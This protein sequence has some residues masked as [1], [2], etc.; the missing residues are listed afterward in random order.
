MKA[1]G[2]VDR[3]VSG[4]FVRAL[5]G[6]IALLAGLFVVLDL[7]HNLARFAD[8]RDAFT[9]FVAYYSLKAPLFISS[10]FPLGALAGAVIVAAGLNRRRELVTLRAAGVSASRAL[11]MVVLLGGLL[12]AAHA[13]LRSAAVPA[14]MMALDVR[15]WLGPPREANPPFV[16]AR[17]D[18]PG[19]VRHWVY[20][21]ADK[22]EIRDLSVTS[23]SPDGTMLWHVAAS[24]A[25]WDGQRW[26]AESGG[27]LFRPGKPPAAFASQ[28]GGPCLSEPPETLAAAQKP[29]PQQRGS[30]LALLPLD[31][32]AATE[33][34]ARRGAWIWP[35]ALVLLSLPWLAREGPRRGSVGSSLASVGLGLGAYA[36]GVVAESLG[37]R[38]L[39][40]AP[41]AG[42]VVPGLFLALG[43][44]LYLFR[45]EC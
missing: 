18:L 38:D 21:R 16:S 31:P 27:L 13:G 29:P 45:M 43:A 22:D 20:R 5:L 9:C 42:T 37:G 32:G 4:G 17:V 11:V 26:N 23:L 19:E 15:G 14:A 8:R 33:Q 1:L 28:A 35:L 41:V 6:T 7:P 3:A 36:L 34:W 12:G 40:P 24:G 10:I 30:E 25:R 44:F 39:L 2:T